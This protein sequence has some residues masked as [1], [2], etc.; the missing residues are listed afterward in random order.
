MKKSECNHVTQRYGDK[1]LKL[2]RSRMG[3]LQ[4]G[5]IEQRTALFVH[6]LF[7]F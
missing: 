3:L 4:C 7:D 1:E 6:K 2:S 5:G